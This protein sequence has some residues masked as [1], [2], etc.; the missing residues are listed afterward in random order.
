VSV[1]GA[2][3]EA[4]PYR[5]D[6]FD[7]VISSLVGCTIQDLHAALDEIVRVLRPGGEFR[8]VEHVAADGIAGR[9]QSVL[10]PA[11]T[12]LAGGCHL[13]RDLEAAYRGHGGLDVT[14][15]ESVRGIPPAAPFI[16]GV[17][18]SS[19]WVA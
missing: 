19:R 5:D 16:R 14:S 6:A 18:V 1:V 11:W 13:D 9:V 17:A 10:D 4:L 7:V 3:G 15:V 8:F 2:R 12:R